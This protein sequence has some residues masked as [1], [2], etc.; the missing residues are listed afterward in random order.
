MI[1]C[2][3]CFIRACNM[4]VLF[5]ASYCGLTGSGGWSTGKLSQKLVEV[6][7]AILI[8]EQ[9][10]PYHIHLCFS[11]RDTKPTR[12]EHMVTIIHTDMW[13][14]L[15]QKRNKQAT[16]KFGDSAKIWLA[17]FSRQKF[18]PGLDIHFI[19]SLTVSFPD[20]QLQ[21][22]CTLYWGSGNETDCHLQLLQGYCVY[23]WS[24]STIIGRVSLPVFW[25]SS[26]IK[27]C[28]WSGMAPCKRI[29]SLMN[30]R[31]KMGVYLC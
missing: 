28:A 15:Q 4:L 23:L 12:N 22:L 25:V 26:E 27:T 11:C 17:T 20:P 1:H 18:K 16:Q 24:S 9:R 10:L 5:A 3:P 31:G 29:M 6:S 2:I 21:Y 13:W 8:L 30:R 7:C 14:E 19:K